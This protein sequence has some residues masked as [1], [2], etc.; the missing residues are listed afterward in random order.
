MCPLDARIVRTVLH[1]WTVVGSLN[2][3]LGIKS[4]GKVSNENIHK[5]A[6]RSF[7]HAHICSVH[8]IVLGPGDTEER[9]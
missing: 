5:L 4:L 7:V 1:R 2:S 6:S 3:T 9:S 8:F